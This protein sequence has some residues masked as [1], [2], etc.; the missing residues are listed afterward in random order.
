MTDVLRR[1]SG[2]VRGDRRAQFGLALFAAINLLLL[3]LYIFS[4]GGQS[5]HLRV[6]ARG[7]QFTVYVDGR[8]QLQQ[9]LDQAAANGGIVLTLGDTQALPSL[10]SPRGIDSIVVTDL[11]S[12]AELFRDDFSSPPSAPTWEVVPGTFYTQD[13]MLRSHGAGSLALRNASWRDYAVDIRYRNVQSTAIAVRSPGGEDGVVTTLRP[14]WWNDD[15]GKTLSLALGNVRRAGG[16]GVNVRLSRIETVKSLLA[17]VLHPYPYI[18][19]LMVIALGLVL[20]LQLVPESSLRSIRES[21]PRAP[22]AWVAIAAA[23]VFFLASLHWN[24]AYRNHIPYVPDAV[25]YIFQARLL[26]SGHVHAPPPPAIFGAFDFFSP[27]PIVQTEGRWAAQY[28]FGHPLVLALG[29]RI[30]AIWLIPPLLGAGTVGMMFVVGRRMYNARVGVLAAVLLATSPFFIMNANDFM[31]H[32]T[33]GFYLLGCLVFLTMLDRRPLLY[34]A[35]A[36]LTFGLLLNTRPLSAAA[37]VPAFGALLLWPLLRARSRRTGAIEVVA[38]AAGALAMVGAYMLYNYGT[39]GDALRTG[40]QASGV[41][42]FTPSAFP[43]SAVNGGGVSQSLG[44]GGQHNALLGLQSERVQA[45]LLV[46]VLDGWP[47]W[48]GLAFVVLPFVLATRRLWDWFLLASALSVMAIWMLY[49]GAGVMYGPRYWYEAMPFLLLL[50]ARGADRA[51]DVLAEAAVFVRTQ[52]FADEPGEAVRGNAD[53]A[54]MGPP[55]WASRVVVFAFVALLTGSSVWGWALSQRPTWRADFVPNTA[56]AMCCV[57]GVDDRVPQLVEQQHLHNALVL[58]EP[59]TNFVCYG[60]V[61]WRNTPTLDGDV[62]YVKDIVAQ[63]AAIVAAFPGRSVY[64]AKYT[65]PSLQPYRPGE[66][67]QLP[68]APTPTATP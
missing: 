52:R 67:P 29:I 66:R 12:G 51:A 17:I 40:Y 1:V 13:G 28:P 10:P 62:V 58:V 35:L 38:F 49:E 41:S 68:G 36:G 11:D 53:Q 61:F 33:A 30:G 5:T 39:T 37:L 18:V 4:R 48:V 60:S 21:M 57:L 19:L 43:S 24:F 46:L 50:A 63:R 23:W 64:I 16:A 8:A 27:S 31:S 34:G 14:F 25:A 55:L 59:C 26:A 7:D 22:A 45:G 54:P 15:T 20:A 42:F 32:N 47:V 3:S 9:Q 65:T 6:E 56:Q 44:I 2:R